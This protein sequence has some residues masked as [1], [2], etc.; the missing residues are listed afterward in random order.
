MAVAASGALLAEQIGSN[1]QFGGYNRRYR[2]STRVQGSGCRGLTGSVQGP[3][4]S[5]SRADRLLLSC[6]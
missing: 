1:K 5:G 2:I 6:V 4:D 3:G